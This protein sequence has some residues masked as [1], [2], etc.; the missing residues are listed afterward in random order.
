[1]ICGDAASRV[2]EIMDCRLWDDGGLYA[3]NGVAMCTAHATDCLSTRVDLE[4][5]R[6]AAGVSACIP[7]QLYSMQR[8]DRWGNPVLKDDRRARGELFGDAEVR[9]LLDEAGLLTSFTH[10][11]K[12]PRTYLLPWSEFVSV[13]ERSHASAQQFAGRRVVVTEKMDGENVTLYRDFMHTRSVA[14]NPHFSREWIEQRWRDI[15]DRIPAGWR[16]CG[17][18]VFATH[19]IEYSNLPSYFLGFSVWN[20]SNVCLDWDATCAFLGELGMA[21]VPV[22]YDGPFDESRIGDV[23]QGHGGPHSEG[24]VLRVA[25]EI[26]YR[27]FRRLVGKFVREDYRQSEPVKRNV[28]HG[29]PIRFNALVDFAL[30]TVG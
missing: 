24:Y 29:E 13:G 20:E 18:Y 23:W 26:P 11:V 5:L 17:E 15:R 6:S 12:Y 28:E 9:H 16:V 27:D 4:T 1:M 25:D 3:D 7:P 10:W 2:Q 22:L 14:A 30:G 21:S 19:T 8:Y